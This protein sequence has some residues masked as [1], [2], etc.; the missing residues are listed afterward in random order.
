[1]VCIGAEVELDVL[2]A[3]IRGLVEEHRTSSAAGDYEGMAVST[4]SVQNILAIVMKEDFIVEQLPRQPGRYAFRHD[5]MQQAAYS[6]SQGG[7][8]KAALADRSDAFST[9]HS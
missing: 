4:D 6:H 8:S 1:M 5:R 2:V 3:A 7:S 9:T